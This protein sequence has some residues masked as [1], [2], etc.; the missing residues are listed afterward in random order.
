MH[1]LSEKEIRHL[2]DVYKASPE[3]KIVALFGA[4]AIGHAMV[5]YCRDEGIQISCIA[6]NNPQ[7]WG[8]D[9]AGIPIISVDRLKDYKPYLIILSGDF[10]K[11]MSSQLASE[12]WNNYL[13]YFFFKDIYE[14]KAVVL[15][16][17]TSVE[18]ACGWILR[19][20]QKNGGVSVFRGSPYEYPEVTGYIIPTMLQYGFRNEALSMAQYLASVVNEDG[21]FTGADFKRTYLFDTA[22]ALRGF[23][24][25]GQITRQYAGLQKKTAE[26]LFSAFDTG[27]GIFP[28]SYEDNPT[29]P[30][31]IMLF[32]LPP[33]LEYARLTADDEKEAMVHKA[34][35]HYLQNPEALSIGTLTHFL[36]YQIDGLIDL[37]YTAEVKGIISRLVAAQK[38]DG[39]IPAYEGVEWVC[40]TGCSQIAICLYKLGI[41]EPADRLM[42]WVEQH[43]ESDGGFL[44][45][46]GAGAEYLEDRELSWAVKFYLDAYKQK[47]LFHFD[48]EFALTAPADRVGLESL[49][50]EYGCISVHSQPIH[51]RGCDE[52]DDLFIKWKCVKPGAASEKKGGERMA[53]RIGI[54]VFYDAQGVVDRNVKWLLEDLR[55]NLTDL[56]IVVNG[57]VEPAGYDFFTS[58]ALKVI[59]REN[60]GFDG[61]AYTDVVCNYLGQAGLDEYEEVVFSNDTY[62]GPFIPFRHVFEKMEDQEIDFWGLS[63]LDM[64]VFSLIDSYFFVVKKR[65][66]K[67][68]DLLSFFQSISGKI[69]NYFEA[70]LYFEIG[71]F[72]YLRNLD[73]RFST[74][75]PDRS[76]HI[77]YEILM[78]EHIDFKMKSDPVL[79]RK[80]F[81]EDYLSDS[82]CF[83]LLNRI[84]NNSDYDVGMILES[85]ERLYGRHLPAKHLCVPVSFEKPQN[86]YFD[87]SEVSFGEIVDFLK[88]NHDVYIYGTGLFGRLTYLLLK[89][90]MGC[91]RGFVVS[92]G[93][94]KLD[95]CCGYPVVYASSL[96]QRGAGILVSLSA[97][98]SEEVKP[99]LNGRNTLYL[100]QARKDA[101]GEGPLLV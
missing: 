88:R 74:Y 59:I 79:K 72:S 10:Y 11:E 23:N 36:A 48:H 64:G 92:D 77:Y 78:D 84:K 95:N 62:Y 43:M 18:R 61:G 94:Q 4:G 16:E 44:G 24:A 20:Q 97:K 47:I 40:I 5:T 29:I 81:S 83:F 91:L 38:E 28:Y 49:M 25:I 51:P 96:P 57:E 30:E 9:I 71:I 21:S 17:A 69:N 32:A 85:I 50:K 33:M 3:N 98:A 63:W 99:C 27:S 42:A 41:P 87:K 65:I 37:G 2:V 82:Q 93:R 56:I 26:F 89:D 60:H 19:N 14:A 53:K 6:D 39:S 66:I 45:S 22:Q 58:I 8:R 35:R 55:A 73:Y 68:G 12:G 46:V 101:A 86:L 80:C 100:F 31:T 70:C 76:V 54:F 67:S 1:A 7:L 13:S 52:R 34:V 90:L 75:T 15:P